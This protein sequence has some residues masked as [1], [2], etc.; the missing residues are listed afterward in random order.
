LG[1]WASTRPDVLPEDLCEYLAQ[2]QAG[3]PH[4]S[5]RWNQRVIYDSFGIDLNELFVEFDAT[6]IGSGTIAQVHQARLKATGESVAVK[7][8]HPHIEASIDRD[9]ILLAGLAG[10]FDQ[11]FPSM[12]WLSLPG[13]VEIFSQMMRA[14]VDLRLEAQTLHR[15]GRNFA[16][17]AKSWGLPQ[18]ALFPE[19]KYPLVA[20]NCL[21]EDLV[22]D[23]VPMSQFISETLSLPDNARARADLA[24]LGFQSFLQMLLWDN[25][26]HADLHPG[27]IL[28]AFKEIDARDHWS[29]NRGV[30]RMVWGSIVG[31]V[32]N[33]VGSVAWFV[34]WRL[35]NSSPVPLYQS[36]LQNLSRRSA[37]EG[38]SDYLRR[39]ISSSKTIP[40]LIFLDT[41]LVAE[42]SRRDFRNFTDLFLALV[43]KQ[44]G[45]LAGRL[46]VERSPKWAQSQVLDLEGF[47]QGM[48]E[49]VHPIL[50]KGKEP[51][52][53]ARS[54][55]FI[56]MIP[57]SLKTLSIAPVLEDV[58][59]LV[60]R[61][62][63]RMDPAFTNLVMSLLCVEGLGRQLAPE[64]DLKPLLLQAA[65]QYLLSGRIDMLQ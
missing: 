14:Q 57:T 32:R 61:H 56:G 58:F 52:N 36:P 8:C 53:P 2:L 34:K 63:V 10:A 31:R 45:A 16:A 1:Q 40:V 30:A 49:V 22:T 6:P 50:G 55:K 12:R 7:I 39:N 65:L 9:L 33:L 62:R 42:L 24:V 13:E 4:H 17:T 54:L 35:L 41:G 26:V 20:Q 48:G 28:V 3:A 59:S 18:R 43:V 64:L 23:A 21:V 60:R 15:F 44:D 19:P 46:M 27:N 47:C 29:Q 51:C 38:I 5:M 37:N 11:F 25:F